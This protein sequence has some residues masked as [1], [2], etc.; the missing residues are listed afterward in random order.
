MV[1]LQNPDLTLQTPA[2]SS[3]GSAV[4]VSAGMAPLTLGTESDGSL[5]IPADRASIYSLKPTHGSI[6][7]HG[8]LSFAAVSDVIGTMGKS[9]ADIALSMNV[10]LDGD[11]DYTQLLGGSL[12]GMKIGFIDPEEWS[13]GVGAI[14][15]NEGY[16]EQSVSPFV[17]ISTSFSLCSLFKV[18]RIPR[19]YQQDGGKRSH[20]ASK[21]Q[22][23]SF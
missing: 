22:P 4:A 7:N 13:S 16:N 23:A 11:T 2:G 9:P 1:S 14:R 8:T 5:I 17:Q 20:C 10:L 21:H 18:E 12:A 19:C 3:S 15:P 6:S